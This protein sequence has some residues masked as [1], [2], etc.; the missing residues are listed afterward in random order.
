MPLVE[1]VD[2]FEDDEL[3]GAEDDAPA[4]LEPLVAGT[5]TFVVPEELNLTRTDAALAALLP[6]ASRASI[7]RWL[8][9]G[10]LDISGKL[11]TRSANKVQTGQTLTLRIP[12]L[13]TSEILPE[14][15]P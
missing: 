7:Q 9:A 10:G 14:D 5:Y 6:Q 12:E 4:E 11:A 13:T 8:E 15:I 3:D 2:G 1:D